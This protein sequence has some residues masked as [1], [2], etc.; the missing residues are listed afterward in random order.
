MVKGEV[1]GGNFFKFGIK[2]DFFLKGIFEFYGKSSFFLK[3]LF[4]GLLWKRFRRCF[5]DGIFIVF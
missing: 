1:T 3:G 5:R 4:F 2:V